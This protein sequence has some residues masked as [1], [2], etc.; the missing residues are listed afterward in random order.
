MHINSDLTLILALN[1]GLHLITKAQRRG[2]KTSG[3]QN[4]EPGKANSLRAG[5]NKGAEP[6]WREGDHKTQQQC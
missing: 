1:G 5:R 6:H 2:K 3:H 4:S